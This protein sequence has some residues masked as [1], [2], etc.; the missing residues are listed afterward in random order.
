MGEIPSPVLAM[1]TFLLLVLG[2]VLT[3]GLGML[4]YIIAANRCESGK[5]AMGASATGYA[6][7]LLLAATLRLTLC[8]FDA[9]CDA[10]SVPAGIMTLGSHMVLACGAATYTMLMNMGDTALYSAIVTLHV[11]VPVTLGIVVLGESL[12]TTQY[13]GVALCCL[14]AFVLGGCDSK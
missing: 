8:T 2:T 10:L 5:V 4:G 3:Q 1:S 12:N 9:E 6:L 14:A 7:M 11:V 13:N